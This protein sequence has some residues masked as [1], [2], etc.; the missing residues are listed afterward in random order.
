V[1][2]ADRHTPWPRPWTWAI[3]L[4]VLLFGAHATIRWWGQALV[5]VLFGDIPTPADAPPL[6]WALLGCWFILSFT[7][8]KVIGSL[9]THH[10]V[11]GA[12][13]P[14]VFLWTTALIWLAVLTFC[15]LQEP[16]TIANLANIDTGGEFLGRDANRSERSAMIGHLNRWRLV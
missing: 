12:D 16:L 8:G 10:P 2:E 14:Q 11:G 4:A 1:P 7:G 3:V 6:V 15:V 5:Q 13:T 9:T